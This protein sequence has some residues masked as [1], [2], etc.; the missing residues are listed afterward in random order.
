MKNVLA[1]FSLPDNPS[2]KRPQIHLLGELSVLQRP[3]TT[4]EWKEWRGP[5]AGEED[6]FACLRPHG[7][8]LRGFYTV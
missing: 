7:N 1:F 4:E 5:S 3:R 6:P 8:L 2:P